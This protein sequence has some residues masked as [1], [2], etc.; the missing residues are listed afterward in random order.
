MQCG[1]LP[2]FLAQVQTQ[3]H[4]PPMTEVPLLPRDSSTRNLILIQ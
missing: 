2:V 3:T 1:P 4:F